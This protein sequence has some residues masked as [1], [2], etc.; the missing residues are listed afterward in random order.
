MLQIPVEN[1]FL[2]PA[3]RVEG[4][5]HFTSSPLKSL[6]LFFYSAKTPKMT[7]LEQKVHEFPCENAKLP[8]CTYFTHI[9][10]GGGGREAPARDLVPEH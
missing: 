4:T 8:H 7:H 2:E 10:V 6:S 5:C 9:R 3:R 1:H